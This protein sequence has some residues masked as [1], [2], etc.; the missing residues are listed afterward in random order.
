MA[1]DKQDS[2][3]HYYTL[4]LAQAEKNKD[5]ESITMMHYRFIDLYIQL[6]QYD[7]AKAIL[8]TVILS[9]PPQET[10]QYATVAASYHEMGKFDSA[11]HYYNII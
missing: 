7:S 10:A 5:K 8:Q 1:F 9:T 4:A 2:I 3:L 11:Q 6:K